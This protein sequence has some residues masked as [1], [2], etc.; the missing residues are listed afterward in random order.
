MDW[1]SIGAALAPVAGTLLGNQQMI[2]QASENRIF[3]RDMSS[4][5]HQREVADLKAA[6]LNPILSA[7]GAGAST[8]GGSMPSLSDLGESISKGSSTAL[9]IKQQ[10][11]QFEQMDTGMRNTNADT[12]NKQAQS[13][14]IQEQTK[15]LKNQQGQVQVDIQRQRM[16]N[17]ILKE[18]LPA[19]IKKAQTEGDYSE[20]KMILELINSGASSAGHLGD[21]IPGLGTA[22]KKLM[23]SAPEPKKK[24]DP[25]GLNLIMGSEKDSTQ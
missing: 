10:G 24:K 17:Q 12:Q 1:A 4:T 21:L 8:P 2:N 25:S 14:Q 7:G 6:G 23:K 20:I 9:A 19:M 22:I 13:G 5:A 3:Q 11:K 18:T 16:Q 15:L